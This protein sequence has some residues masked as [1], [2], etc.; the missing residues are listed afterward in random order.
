MKSKI[1]FKDIEIGMF[2]FEGTTG[3]YHQKLSKTTSVVVCL[4]TGKKY[5]EYTF[6]INHPVEHVDDCDDC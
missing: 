3:E 5:D 4:D 6:G 1:E 2:F